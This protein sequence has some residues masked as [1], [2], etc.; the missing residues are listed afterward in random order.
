[1]YCDAAVDENDESF[2]VCHAGYI[3]L[4][5]VLLGLVSP[6]NP[7]LGPVLDLISDPE[8]LWS[9]YG[10]RSL[11]KKDTF[12]G[13]GENY[14]RGPIWVPLN[15]MAL[16]ALT[17]KYAAEPG[18]LQTKAAKIYSE[19]RQNLIDNT[20]KVRTA[21]PFVPSSLS[22]SCRL[23]NRF[24]QEYKRTGFTWEQFNP[25]T[26]LGQRS[27]PFTGWSSTVALIMAEIY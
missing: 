6:T 10:I 8:H 7:R 23:L 18:P 24:L 16:K 27:H 11:S 13:K 4:F 2:H 22:C 15:Y 20:F 21:L 25:E 17:Q 19:L 1:M 12:F 9:P 26:G 5:P 14:W 3:S